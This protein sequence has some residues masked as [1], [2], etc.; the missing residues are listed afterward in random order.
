M[1]YA[2][3][4]A[5]LLAGGDGAALITDVPF[6]CRGIAPAVPPKCRGT[7]DSVGR[8]VVV[9]QEITAFVASHQPP[10]D[11][12]A[13]MRA[14]VDGAGSIDPAALSS[15]E[16]IVAQNAALRIALYA[17]GYRPEIAK[18]ALALVT[19]LALPRAT[20][21]KMGDEPTSGIEQWIGPAEEWRLKDRRRAPHF[22]AEVHQHVKYFRP[23][24]AGT[25]RAIFS[26][27]I[28]VDEGGRVHLT[29]VVGELEIRRGREIGSAACVGEIDVAYLRCGAPAGLRMADLATHPTT[30]FFSPVGRDRVRCPMCHGPGSSMTLPEAPLAE[31][32]ALLAKEKREAVVAAARVLAELNQQLRQPASNP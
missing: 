32:P 27:L 26:Q 23:V 3:L 13:R 5:L 14:A 19:R 6:D 7:D 12:W 15:G 10:A 30:H 24:Q 11:R 18:P 16:R 29:G 20:L 4:A 25:L 31:V 1:L 9:A 28:A 22:H 21:E 2:T 8:L 17:G